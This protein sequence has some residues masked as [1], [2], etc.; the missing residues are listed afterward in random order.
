MKRWV[1]WGSLA[2]LVVVA[3]LLLLANCANSLVYHPHTEQV[4]PNFANTEAVRI[5]TEDDERLVAWYRAPA[6]GQ[7]IFFFFD[8]NAG[9]PQIWEG[10][11][12]RIPDTHFTFAARAAPVSSALHG[13]GAHGGRFYLLQEIGRGS[14][15]A[16]GDAFARR[17]ARCM[18]GD[19]F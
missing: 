9:R 12:R 4:A 17:G 14:C 13:E 15:T 8:G 18:E 1:K 5:E 6:E 2:A 3:P 10:R 16:V 7:P 19:P 11:W